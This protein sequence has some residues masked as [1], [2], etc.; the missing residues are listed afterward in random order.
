MM[1]SSAVATVGPFD[2][3]HSHNSIDINLY[4]SIAARLAMIRK[5]FAYVRLHTGQDTLL[6]FRFSQGTGQLAVMAERMDAVGYLI[7]SVLVE[8]ESYR[9]WLTERLLFLGMRCSDLTSQL[10]Q[11]VNWTWSERLQAA[12]E[13]IARLIPVQDSFILVDQDQWGPKIFANRHAIP[14]RERN[15]KYW[16]CPPDKDIAIREL[17]RLRQAGANFIV[18]G[19]PAFWWLDYYVGF[20]GYLSAK[21]RCVLKIS[22]LVVFD[23]RP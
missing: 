10:V 8:D 17:E 9:F 22:R 14:F 19:W 5:E 6:R 13:E 11:D 18:F 2:V 12:I 20:R 4:L 7:Q 21:F 23:L 16:G 15:G 1:R 3:T